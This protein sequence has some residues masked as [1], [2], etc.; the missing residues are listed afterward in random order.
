M[1]VNQQ[2]SGFAGLGLDPTLLSTL[3]RHGYNQPTPIQASV[4][5]LAVEG[6]DLIGIAQTGTGKTLAFTAPILNAFLSGKARRAIVLAPTRELALQIEET[7]LVIGKPLGFRSVCLIGGASMGR[8]IDQLKSKPHFIVAT[9]GRLEDHIQ[10]RRLSLRDVD[11]AVLDEADRMLDMGFLPAVKRIMEHLPQEL[12]VL[13]L[14]ATMP[15]EIASLAE[16]FMNDPA[17]V[18]M[19]QPGTPIDLIRQELVVV[20]RENKNDMLDDVLRKNEGTALV[21]ARTRHGA[22]KVAKIVRDMGH[23][24][25]EIHSDRTMA[26]RKEALEGFKRGK[27]RVLVAT[28]IASRGIDVKNIGVVINYDLPDNP[29]DYVHRIGR[30]GRAGEKG[31]AITFAHPDQSKEIRIIEK[32]IRSSIPRGADSAPEARP[33]PHQHQG[34]RPSNH[35]NRRQPAFGRPARAAVRTSR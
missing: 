24:A 16:Q 5:P 28:D 29:E 4:I 17:T 15:N 9:P 11:I 33:A 22:R 32:L 19:E 26:Q 1:N 14:S 3:S 25:A 13:L 30:T 18:K 7:F 2:E 34:A 31:L 27:Y 20:A 23:A 6:K 35:R 10:T 12:Q 21:F 8:Q